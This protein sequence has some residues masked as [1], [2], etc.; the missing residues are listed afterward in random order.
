MATHKPS[1]THFDNDN[2]MNVAA[3]YLC[4]SILAD[5][6]WAPFLRITLGTYNANKGKNNT[7]WNSCVVGGG[8]FNQYLGI[9]EPL[10]V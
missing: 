3:G 5:T 8:V 2:F 1:L 9:R 6:I 10:R 4:I 7:L